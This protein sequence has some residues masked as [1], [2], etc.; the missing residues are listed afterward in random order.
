[1]K[2]RSLVIPAVLIALLAG[3]TPQTPAPSQNPTSSPSASTPAPAPTSAAPTQSPVALVD[4]C[5][6][7]VA[8]DVVQRE[9]SPHFVSIPIGAEYGDPV[10]QAFLNDGGLICLWGI[11]QSGAG[12][13]MYVAEGIAGSDSEQASAWAA[14]GY[15]QCAEFDVCYYES[16]TNEEGSFWT[17]HALAG[18]FELRV[19]AQSGSL[20]P[21]MAVAHE[22]AT[23]MGYI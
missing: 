22:A 2:V 3:C 13:T 15:T 20:D 18:G 4:S 23:N 12:F 17:L 6:S 10:A 5:D 19:F 16:E 14:A 9:F 1:M 8:L 11:P 7:L 21:L